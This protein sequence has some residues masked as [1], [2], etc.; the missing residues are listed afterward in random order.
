LAGVRPGSPDPGLRVADVANPYE[1]KAQRT[2]RAAVVARNRKIK[3]AVGGAA[4]LVVL[5]V[6]LYVTVFSRPS[7]SPQSSEQLMAGHLILIEGQI[8][9]RVT[10]IADPTTP[11]ADKVRLQNEVKALEKGRDDLKKQLGK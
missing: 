11:A 6:V 5:L 3:W 1:S 8:Q 4:A 10:L 7:S 2:E 9:S